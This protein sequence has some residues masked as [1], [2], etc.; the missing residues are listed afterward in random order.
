MNV[1]RRA[2]LGAAAATAAA[3]M[4]RATAQDLG[5]PLNVRK[6]FPAL[7]EL[8]FLNTAYAGLIPQPVADAARQW[9]E[10]RA[11]RSY[12][13]GEMFARAD[14][15]RALLARMLGAG[16]DEIAFISS[17]TEGENIVVNSLDFKAGDNIVYDD[18]VY[19][20]T[21]AI[22]QKLAS[23]RGVEVRVVKSRNGAATVEDFAKLVDRRTR[24]ISVA[25]VNNN[26]GYRHDM[27]ALANLAH[28]HGAYLYSDAVQFIGTGP[29]DVHAEGVDFFTTGTYKWLMAGF[30]VAAFYVRRE[31][32]EQIQPPYVGW[33]T[34]PDQQRNSKKFEYATLP[35]GEL[36]ELAASLEYLQRIGLD[37]IEARSQ[38]LVQRLR[39]GLAQRQIAIATPANNRSPIVSFYIRRSSAEATKMME[40]ERVRVSFQD[41]APAAGAPGQ[42]RVRVAI[43]FFN[44]EA[45]IDRMLTMAEKLRA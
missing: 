3:S 34:R 24:L 7:R 20:S 28:G 36:Y 43:A 42:T 16:E 9:I 5:D 41:L 14:E 22:Y 13:V 11:M 33:R 4:S 44:N 10:R 12:T 26:S 29:V 19:P 32:M 15:A 18:L 35:F 17:T 38:V 23:T 2:F 40:A 6:D 30:G 37:T 1:T 39:N 21:P 25:W 27:K 8:T 31:L 45:D